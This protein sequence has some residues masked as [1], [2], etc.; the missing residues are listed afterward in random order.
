MR[1][2]GD[3]DPA[4]A[5]T[6]ADDVAGR[7]QLGRHLRRVVGV[8]VVDG[9]AAGPAAELEPAPD[10]VEG[11]QAGQH[12]L[13]VGAQLDAREQRT[14]RVERHVRPRHGQ[15][16]QVLD[17]REPQDDPGAGAV[18]AEVDEHGVGG[19]HPAVAAD[20]D[21]PLLR[22]LGERGGA[23][24]VDAGHERPAGR[25]AAPGT[26]RTRRRRPARVP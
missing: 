25:D 8:V 1:L 5:G 21:A 20:P 7:A 11:G 19:R 15:P 6:R 17:A 10:P 14:E 26:R 4:G 22:R 12:Q 24:V 9:D 16:Q 3:D 18:G 2:E 23:G 13:G